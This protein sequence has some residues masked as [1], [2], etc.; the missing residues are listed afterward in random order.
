MTMGVATATARGVTAAEVCAMAL[1]A[2]ATF[3][4]RFLT[5][6]QFPN[7]HFVHVAIGQQ[8]AGGAWP[9]RDYVERGK[10]DARTRWARMRHVLSD[11]VQ[12]ADLLK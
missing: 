8:M 9:V 6:T 11:M 7:D 10:P 12:P 4:Y 5:F 3:C 2:G 1:A